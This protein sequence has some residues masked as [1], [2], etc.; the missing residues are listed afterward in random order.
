MS[1]EES[2]QIIEATLKEKGIVPYTKREVEIVRSVE[3]CINCGVCINHC[4]VIRAVGVDRFTGPRGIA[5]ELSRSPPEFWTSVDRIYLCTG[6]GT[7]REVCPKNVDIPD[8]VNLMR[9]RIYTQRPDLVPQS[10]RDQVQILSEYNLAFEPWTDREE[11]VES[12]D[13]RLERLGLPFIEDPNKPDAE[14]LFYPGCQAEERAQEVREAAKIVLHHFNVDFTVLE[15]MSC[16]GLP[17]TLVGDSEKSIELAN[18]LRKKVKD[19][20][21]KTIVTTCAGC[22]SNLNEIVERD[23]WNVPVYH[24]LEYL[25]EV[26]GLDTLS[27]EF[28]KKDAPATRVTVHDPCHLIRHTS[29]RIMEYA[30]SILETIPSVEVSKS[31]AHDSC[32]GGGGMVGRH[33]PDVARGVVRENVDAILETGAEKVVTPCPLCTAQL[34][35]NLFRHGSSIDVEDLTVLIARNLKRE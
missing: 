13:M 33:S 27:K 23:E 29:R 11:K 10:L 2:R 7:C 28:I 12:R 21:V 6:C 30:V 8:L 5:V 4:P 15:D 16:C 32:C 31:A 19:L 24:I 3:K 22:T 35:E 34:E 25:S 14:V 20:G 9:R 18:V 1:E 17:A 26:I